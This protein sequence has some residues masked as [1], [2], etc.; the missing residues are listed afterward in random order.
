[1]VEP[2][3]FAAFYEAYTQVNQIRLTTACF[4]VN[5]SFPKMTIA[6]F[7]DY[8]NLR[9]ASVLNFDF[10]LSTKIGVK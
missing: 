9:L 1:M 8:S 2:E 3:T 10:N 4:F 5:N 6:Y 7:H